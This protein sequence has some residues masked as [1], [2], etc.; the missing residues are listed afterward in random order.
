[1]TDNHVSSRDSESLSL[2]ELVME[3]VRSSVRTGEMSEDGWYSVYQLAAQL[4]YSRSPVREGLLRLE[5]AGLIQFVKNRGFR[6]VPTTPEDVAEIFS[7]RIALEVPA[8]R[9]AARS[10]A[11]DRD[12]VEALKSG[13][14]DA[15]ARE[16][17][18]E[19]FRIDRQLHGVILAAGGAKRT[20]EIVDRLRTTTRLLGA[21]TARSNRSFDDIIAEHEPI[22]AAILTADPEAAGTAMRAHL[23]TTGQILVDQALARSGRSDD[24][25]RLWEELT[26]DWF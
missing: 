17:E 9:R 5:E 25:G 3:H 21:S 12:G 1:M 8:A 10:G 24:A 13:M 26:A 7:I 22:L 16:D 11:L 2:T 18:D 6:I 4:G 23:A 15:A 14:A 20:R 19:F